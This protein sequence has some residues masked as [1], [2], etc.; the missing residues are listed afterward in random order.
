MP[1]SQTHKG[2]GQADK[3]KQHRLGL[4]VWLWLAWASLQ[5]PGWPRPQQLSSSW[6]TSKA[7]L[8]ALL[9]CQAHTK[10]VS[11]LSPSF[12]ITLPL[13]ELSWHVP[14]H[15]SLGF[16]VKMGQFLHHPLTPYAWRIS[17]NAFSSLVSSTLLLLFPMPTWKPWKFLGIAEL[18]H[19]L[20]MGFYTIM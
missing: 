19:F 2:L 13:L 1:S 11:K 8:Q 15:T 12:P 6:H 16:V 3:T 17:L 4:S 18:L 9:P 5:A 7:G 20:F 14:W 10:S